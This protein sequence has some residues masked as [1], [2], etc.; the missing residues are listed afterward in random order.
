MAL[1]QL[2]S[3]EPFG[4]P[5]VDDNSK[6]YY[7]PELRHVRERL[8]DLVGRMRAAERWPWKGSVLTLYRDNVLPRLCEQLPAADEAARWQAAIA[9]ETARLDAAE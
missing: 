9:A 4:A 8:E 5:D 6:L 2:Q 7:L 3:S 1:A